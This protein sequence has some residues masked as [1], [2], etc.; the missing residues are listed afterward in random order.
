MRGLRRFR[1]RVHRRIGAD[2]NP[3]AA[4][5]Y[6]VMRNAQPLA[7]FQATGTF[8]PGPALSLQIRT[9]KR[10]DMSAP[11]TNVEKQ[12]KRHRPVL[13]G[14]AIAAVFVAILYFA[15]LANLAVQGNEPGTSE[16]DGATSTVVDE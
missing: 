16:E 15:Y 12:K 3:V 13:L 8:D 11:E 9:T 7:R 6:L 4:W 14:F 10:N 1:P 2:K 5:R